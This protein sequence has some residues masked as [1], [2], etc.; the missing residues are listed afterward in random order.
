MATCSIPCTVEIVAYEQFTLG[1]TMLPGRVI[2]VLVASALF[3]GC[4]SSDSDVVV[5]TTTSTTTLPPFVSNLD[6]HI[7][8]NSPD[9][10]LAEPLLETL[11]IVE[12]QYP[13][14]PGTVVLLYSKTDASVEWAL[15]KTKELKCMDYHSKANLQVALGWSD[16]CGIAMRLDGRPACDEIRLCR[17]TIGTAAH[18]FL[19][20]MNLQQYGGYTDAL[21]RWFSEGSATYFGYMFTYGDPPGELSDRIVAQLRTNLK[22]QS[23]VPEI[24]IP[25]KDMDNIWLN[26]DLSKPVPVWIP[27]L[28]NRSFLAVSLLIEKFGEHAVFV[29]YV[30]NFTEM[31]D[32]PKAFEKTFGITEDA[33]YAEFQAW[34]DAL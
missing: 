8:P 1:E 28:Y 14:R 32:H 29:E 18:E 31:R 34:I 12:R 4:T 13:V 2:G 22:E 10:Q 15:N 6:I 30:D 16:A 17:T 7:D 20:V 24:N 33:F 21:S 25:F 26:Q 19:H 9:T 5:T 11:E 27:Y 3:M 23:R